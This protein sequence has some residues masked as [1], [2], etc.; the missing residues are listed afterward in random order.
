M[1]NISKEYLK[2]NSVLS[3]SKKYKITENEVR[4]FLK[5]QI[6][7]YHKSVSDL[8]LFEQQEILRK[9]SNQSYSVIEISDEYQI[10]APSVIKLL[11]GLGVKR[12]YHKGRRYEILKQTPFNKKQKE[13]ITGTLLGD[14]CIRK[15]GKLPRL[16]LV[17]SKKYEQYFHWKIS[18]LDKHFNLWRE[19]KDKRK[20]STLL[21]TETLQHNGLLE[22]Y[23]WFYPNKT[24]IVPDNLDKYMTPYALAVWFLDDGTLN[25]GT[26]HRIHTNCFSYEDQLKLKHLLKRCFDLNCKI[27]TRRD[28]QHILSFKRKDTVKLS[29]IIEPYVVPCMKYKLRLSLDCSSTTIRQTTENK[30]ETISHKDWRDEW[31]EFKKGR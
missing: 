20:N 24:K 18:Q 15:S 4:S 6:N 2:G 3:L 5:T 29:N 10:S 9:Y 30:S 19:Q 11:K 13:F 14:G 22:F 16:C 17:H 25:S 23:N 28:N 27:L 8:S 7:W 1:K 21:Y 26:N 12:V 31:N